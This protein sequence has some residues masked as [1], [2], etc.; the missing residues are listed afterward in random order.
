MVY[1]LRRGEQILFELLHRQPHPSHGFRFQ[2]Q[3]SELRFSRHDILWA[4]SL[5]RRGTHLQT[6]LYH[7][8]PILLCLLVRSLQPFVLGDLLGTQIF[9]LHNR[10][11]K[12][13]EKKL[14]WA[15]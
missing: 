7:A 10:F 15:D 2:Y 11:F 6:V 14:F 13:N 4:L 9:R 8:F 5:F 12:N 1:L 3:R